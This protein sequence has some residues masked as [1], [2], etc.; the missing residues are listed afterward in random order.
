MTTDDRVL[1]ERSQ[2]RQ[3]LLNLGLN[4]MDAMPQGGNL[5]VRL[6]A[7]DRQIRIELK[8]TGGGIP[9]NLLPTIHMPFI[10]TK[11]NGLGLGL[12]KAYA[13]IEEHGGSIEIA[14]RHEGGARVSILLTRL[15]RALGANDTAKVVPAN[16]EKR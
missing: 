16:N 4:A 8:D 3:V 7:E 10:S 6:H 13:I 11:K 2:I 1:G 12:S 15:I 14:N 9:P 5:S